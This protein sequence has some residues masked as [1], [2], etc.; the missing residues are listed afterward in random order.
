MMSMFTE[1]NV[2]ALA[3]AIEGHLNVF[4][5]LES[6]VV[7]H[8]WNEDKRRPAANTTITIATAHHATSN[9]DRLTMAR[10]FLIYVGSEQI[11]ECAVEWTRLG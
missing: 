4:K 2:I 7:G 10:L 11:I 6:R 8:D 9:G 3:A 1:I 5:T